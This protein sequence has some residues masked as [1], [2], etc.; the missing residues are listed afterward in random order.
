MGSAE[1]GQ[2]R[3]QQAEQGGKDAGQGAKRVQ[4]E[5]SAAGSGF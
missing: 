1:L 2:S 4:G 3:E 5:Q